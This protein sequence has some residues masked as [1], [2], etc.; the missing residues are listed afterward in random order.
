MASDAPT[1]S[2]YETLVAAQGT[3]ELRPGLVGARVPGAVG[4]D[5]GAFYM[6]K[7][8][9]ASVLY[10]HGQTTHTL[11]AQARE[12]QRHTRRG[13][14]LRRSSGIVSRAGPW[15]AQLALRAGASRGARRVLV[16][17][18][19]ALHTTRA[20]RRARRGRVAACGCAP[21]FVKARVKVG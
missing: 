13:W 10:R 12:R 5:G 16:G 1:P 8:D 7:G 18:V 14:L 3:K 21:V 15:A 20:A 17:L 19:V 6:V 11:G 4:A 2:Y 9:A